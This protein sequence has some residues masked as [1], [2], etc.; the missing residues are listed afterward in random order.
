MHLL[1]IPLNAP[2]LPAIPKEAL[3]TIMISAKKIER[4]DRFWEAVAADVEAQLRTDGHVIHYQSLSRLEIRERVRDVVR[5]LQQ[6]MTNQNDEVLAARFRALGDIRCQQGIPL[7][8]V[9]YKMAIIKQKLA[10]R[11][12]E[13]DPSFGVI[14]VYEEYEWMRTIERAFEIVTDALTASYD[15][16]RAATTRSS[17]P[18]ASLSASDANP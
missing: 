17:V 1:G 4:L 13:S 9:I 5:H 12:L 3:R 6:W 18:S 2:A 15:A 11:V 14:E 8:E 16:S 10:R 7:H